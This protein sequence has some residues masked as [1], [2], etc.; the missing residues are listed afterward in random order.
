M[1]TTP[2]APPAY[3]SLPPIEHLSDGRPERGERRLLPAM[4]VPAHEGYL[5]LSAL[6]DAVGRGPSP[7]EALEGL[8]LAAG[9]LDPHAWERVARATEGVVLFTLVRLE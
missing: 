9:V 1:G 4:V 2:P 7:E 8:R 3:V 5:A 6:V